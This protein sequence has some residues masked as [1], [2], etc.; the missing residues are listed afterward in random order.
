MLIHMV[1]IFNIEGYECFELE[2]TQTVTNPGTGTFVSVFVLCL[3]SLW[4]NALPTG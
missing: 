4:Y 3:G 1:D 2:N